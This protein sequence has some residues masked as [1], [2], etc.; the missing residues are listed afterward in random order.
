MRSPVPPLYSLAEAELGHAVQHWIT[1]ATSNCY[2]FPDRQIE[3]FRQLLEDCIPFTRRQ[4]LSFVLLRAIWSAEVELSKVFHSTCSDDHFGTRRQ[5]Q[6]VRRSVALLPL[7]SLS[8]LDLTSSFIPRVLHSYLLHLLTACTGLRSLAVSCSKS[9]VEQCVSSLNC[10]NL[11]TSLTLHLTATDKLVAKVTA[12]LGEQLKYLALT[13]SVAVTED[14]VQSISTCKR[15]EVLDLQGTRVEAT[16]LASLL[17]GLP[18]LRQ[19]ISTHSI[20]SLL[21]LL[22][23]HLTLALQICQPSL[24]DIFHPE[25]QMRDLASRCPQMKVLHYYS[26]PE[27]EPNNFGFLVLFSNLSSLTLSG[28]RFED[29]SLAPSL[30]EI[31]PFLNSLT[32]HHVEDLHLGGIAEVLRSCPN[33]LFLSLDL[34][35]FLEQASSSPSFNKIL[36]ETHFS[37]IERLELTG[38]VPL[39]ISSLLLL[40]STH[41]RRIHLSRPPVALLERLLVAGHLCQLE[42]FSSPSKELSLT[43]AALLIAH[44]PNLVELRSIDC[45]GQKE[46]VARWRREVKEANMIIETGAMLDTEHCYRTEYPRPCFANLSSE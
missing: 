12:M 30:L 45:W 18:K 11:L 26:N 7:S 34:C 8:C 21:P 9:E 31:G 4:E 24:P 38:E 37:R 2:D 14:A 28:G 41:L 15:L 23:P 33:L 20:P 6:L 17:A 42:V 44:C 40:R 27:E 5:I 36:R 46:E 32:L 3:K 43:T 35:S 13:Q 19:L 25:Q 39:N 10:L 16:G 1:L 29:Q 22:P